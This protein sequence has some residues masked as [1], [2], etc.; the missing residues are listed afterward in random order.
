LK[1]TICPNWDQ[2]VVLDGLVL[3]GD[4]ADNVEFAPQIVCELFDHDTFGAD[5]FL[6]RLVARPVFRSRVRAFS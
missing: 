3:P 5:D 2:V 1:Q 4:L 6:G